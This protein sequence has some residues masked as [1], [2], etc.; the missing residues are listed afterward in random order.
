MPVSGLQLGH[1][2]YHSVTEAIGGSNMPSTCAAA[3]LSSSAI[4]H[5]AVFSRAATWSGREGEIASRK[6]SSPLNN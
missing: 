2:A 6:L 1:A 5:W 4:S 3:G